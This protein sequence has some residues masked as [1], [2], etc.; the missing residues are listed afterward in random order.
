MIA[1]ML[2]A[3]PVLQLPIACTPG[4][5]CAV[6]SLP[7]HDP[8]P[9]ARDYACGDHTYD[10][11]DGTDFRIP[12]MARQR[13]GVNVLA[14]AAG[15]VLRVRDGMADISMRDAAF[16]AGQDCGN[17]LVIDHGGGWES[18]YCHMAKGSVVAK[19]GQQV[20]A[21]A[22]LGKVGL[23]GNTEFPHVHLT[24]RE[25]G[26]AVDPFAY[27]AA[28]G[29][30]RGG[31]S[32]WAATP[33]YRRGEV[34]VAGFAAGPVTMAQAQELGAAQQPAPGR[35]SPLVAFVQAIGLEGGD[36]QRL[37]VT[38]PDG[39]TLADNRAQPLDR[40]KA[41]TILFAGKRAPAAGW[42]G[43]RYRARYSVIR[44][45]KEAIMREFEVRL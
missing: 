33:A 8:G 45:G 26:K 2:A 12:S 14:A 19:P 41:Q 42:P 9:G 21:G 39:Q 16:A 35:T 13:A 29:Q 1:L 18:Q 44:Q 37:V 32:L 34:L 4:M 3:A 7:D 6:Q 23:S 20:A 31:R 25:N 40:A 22:V 27:G 30:C 24:V 11:H 17:G 43:G 28:A 5:D 15:T 36:V 38:G 10:K